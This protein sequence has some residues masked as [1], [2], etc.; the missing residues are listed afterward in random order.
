VRAPV[1]EIVADLLLCRGPDLNRRHMVLQAR[2]LRIDP[3]TWKYKSVRSML[4][5][6]A[7]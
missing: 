1:I 5:L 4:R 2:T 6:E 7:R 3:I